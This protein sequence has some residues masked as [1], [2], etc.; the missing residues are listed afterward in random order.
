MFLEGVNN[1]MGVNYRLKK[2]GGDGENTT[3]DQK[4]PIRHSQWLFTCSF[5]NELKRREKHLLMNYVYLLTSMNYVLKLLVESLFF[6]E[7]E[8][9]DNIARQSYDRNVSFE[10][11]F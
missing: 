2:S 3:K 11:L 7:L 6:N 9:C 10:M 8:L 5:F 4:L 1:H